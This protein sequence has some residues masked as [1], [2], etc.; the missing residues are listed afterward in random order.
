MKE[1]KHSRDIRGVEGSYWNGNVSARHN[2]LRGKAETASVEGTWAYQK[3][4]IYYSSR[5]EVD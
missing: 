2:G 3:E 4:E 5:E 1:D